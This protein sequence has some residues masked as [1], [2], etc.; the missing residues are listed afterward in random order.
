[1]SIGAAS[2]FISNGNQNSTEEL[3]RSDARTAM[4]ARHRELCESPDLKNARDY[5]DRLI[6]TCELTCRGKADCLRVCNTTRDVQLLYLEGVL[7]GRGACPTVGKKTTG[8]AL[9]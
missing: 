1:M 6:Q 3:S 5:M 8:K 9:R 7:S 2:R 4:L